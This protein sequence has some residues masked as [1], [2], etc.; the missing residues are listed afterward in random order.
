MYEN[1]SIRV[2][3]ESKLYYHNHNHK[4]IGQSKLIHQLK[5]KKKALLRW[6]DF[7]IHVTLKELF[8][9]NF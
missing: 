4:L 9:C 3:A 6:R 5:F 8:L 7:I 2:H 1:H